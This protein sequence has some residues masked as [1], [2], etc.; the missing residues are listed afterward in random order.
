MIIKILGAIV[1]IVSLTTSAY[2]TA[3]PSHRPRASLRQ[4]EK[5]RAAGRDLETCNEQR[6]RLAEIAVGLEEIADRAI[7]RLESMTAK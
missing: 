5:F 4:L 2:F 6:N 3:F 7:T 1:G